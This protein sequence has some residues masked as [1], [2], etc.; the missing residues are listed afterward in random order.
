MSADNSPSRHR[1]PTGSPVMDGGLSRWVTSDETCAVLLRHQ[2]HPVARAAL[3]SLDRDLNE[4]AG[5]SGHHGDA[6]ARA[7][8]V[9][10]CLE[11]QESPVSRLSLG[12]EERR[13]A[14]LDRPAGALPTRH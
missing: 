9:A 14:S 10:W 6:H 4:P 11:H 2:D 8:H 3:A 7:L 5:Y 12:F 1:Y 13:I